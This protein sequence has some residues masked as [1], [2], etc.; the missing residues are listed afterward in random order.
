ME[1]GRARG[2]A[3]RPTDRAPVEVAPPDPTPSRWRF[4]PVLLSAVLAFLL[5][6][7]AVLVAGRLFAIP[8]G[9]LDQLTPERIAILTAAVP[10]RR[11]PGQDRLVRRAEAELQGIGEVSAVERALARVPVPR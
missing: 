6:N 9:H 5:A 1:R 7:A 11:A 2:G 3:P 10:A 4:W 8:I